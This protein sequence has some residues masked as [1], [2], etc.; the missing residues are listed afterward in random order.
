MYVC[1]IYSA[2]IYTTY[3]TIKTKI[4]INSN[5][6]INNKNDRKIYKNTYISKFLQK[7]TSGEM[8]KLI[9]NSFNLIYNQ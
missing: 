1:T 3:F 8:V 9:N 4:I 5:N 6:N 7:I 2:T